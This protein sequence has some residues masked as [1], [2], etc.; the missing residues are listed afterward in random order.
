MRNYEQLFLF[1]DYLC[2]TYSYGSRTELNNMIYGVSQP[3]IP[4]K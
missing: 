2:R 4:K 1:G 3:L